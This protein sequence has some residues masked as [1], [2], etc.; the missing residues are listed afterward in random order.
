MGSD[1]KQTRGIRGATT[2]ENNSAE[3]I[4]SATREL[5]NKIVTDNSIDTRDI[6]AVFFSATPDLNSAFPAKAAR[7]IGWLDVPLFCQ[8][9]I[10]VPGSLG[11]CIRIMM[12]VNSTLEPEE[13]KHIY[14]KET[15]NLR[16]Q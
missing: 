16:E 14:L 4:I 10:D 11:K 9:E 2:V 8:V 15:I 5:L 3:E 1:K 13:I 7:E 12:L 6:A